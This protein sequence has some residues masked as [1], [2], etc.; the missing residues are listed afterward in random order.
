MAARSIGL[1]PAVAQ[2]LRPS[3]GAAACPSITLQDCRY[4]FSVPSRLKYWLLHRIPTI[5]T[6]LGRKRKTMNMRWIQLV[7][8]RFIALILTS[9][10]ALALSAPGSAADDPPARL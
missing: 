1:H 2:T 6:R 5:R 3:K 7:T 8:S 10:T 4:Q 9:T